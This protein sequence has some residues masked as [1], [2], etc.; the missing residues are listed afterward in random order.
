MTL[1]SDHPRANIFQ[2]A[3]IAPALSSPPLSYPAACVPVLRCNPPPT[4]VSQLVS[5]PSTVS[6]SR[7]PR[8]YLNQLLIYH[9]RRA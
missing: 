7:R 8:R 6:A 5:L 4:S 1:H 9:S 2:N 3:R